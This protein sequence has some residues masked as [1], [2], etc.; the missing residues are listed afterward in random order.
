MEGSTWEESLA[1][2][3]EGEVAGAMWLLLPAPEKDETAVRPVKFSP[4]QSSPVQS[5]RVQSSPVQ[6]SPAPEKETAGTRLPFPKAHSAALRRAEM[7]SRATSRL[8]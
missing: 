6:S 1:A 7:P 8:S 3:A 4:V 2:E 5:S